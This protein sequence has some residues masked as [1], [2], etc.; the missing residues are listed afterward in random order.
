MSR[1]PKRKPIRILQINLNGSI[2]ATESALDLAVE[3]DI[4]VI[5]AQEPWVLRHVTE[6]YN[7]TRSINHSDFTQILPKP[8]D[9]DT[10]PRTATW[11][12]KD[13]PYDIRQ[14]PLE[15]EPDAQ[16][17]DLIEGEGK[18]RLV[19]LY[20][21]K[22]L[23]TGTLW[24]VERTLLRNEA[25]ATQ[26]TILL[27]D[28]NT[29]H[30]WW[31]PQGPTPNERATA[32]GEWLETHNFSL[33]N[34]IGQGTFYRPNMEQASVLDLVFTR[35]QASKRFQD[36]QLL[37]SL[38]SDHL[39][40]LFSLQ[41]KAE[42]TPLKE[43]QTRLN[44]AKADWDS[45]SRY[46][47][48]AAENRLPPNIVTQNTPI[49]RLAN[50][51]AEDTE[52]LD[53]YTKTLT[54][55]IQDAVATAIPRNK[56]TPR[57]KAWWTKELKQHRLFLQQAYRETKRQQSSESYRT[58]KAAKNR[59][60]QEIKQAKRDHWNQFLEGNSP[61][62][63]FKAMQYTKDLRRDQIPDIQSTASQIW[64]QTSVLGEAA[65][66]VSS[67]AAMQTSFSGKCTA[68]R[69]SLFPKPPWKPPPIW[70]EYT[71]DTDTWEWPPLSETELAS[72]CSNKKI[73][74]KAPGPDGI[75]QAII[76]KA[77]AAIPDTFYC[78]YSALLNIGYHPTGWKQATGVI[79]KKLGKP[80]YSVPKAYRV[81]SLLN[82]LGKV[83][84]RILAR[85]LGYLA[86]TTTLLHNS[87]IGGR[88]KKSAIDTAFILRNTV[89]RN[90]D[91]GRKTS[92][93]FLDVKGAFD[94][95]AKNQLLTIM[96]KLRLPT[97]LIAWTSSF[98][99]HRLLR[100]QFNGETEKFSAIETGIPQGSPISPILFLIYIRDLFAPLQHVTPLS[101]ID[102]IALTTS[103]TSLRKNARTL[104]EAAAT[105]Y[106]LGKDNAIEFDLAKTELIH[107]SK[108]K[109]SSTKV[110]L[111][112]DQEVIPKDIVKWLGFYFDQHL[113]FK[114]HI[115]TRT[116]QARQ[117]FERMR[118]LASTGYGLSFSALRNI[119][120]AC[121]LSI[122]D[123]G[124]PVWATTSKAKSRPLQAL[125]SKA[126][127]RILGV[128]K[129]APTL[130]S[131]VE[132]ALPPTQIRLRRI[133]QNY[134]LRSLYL[135][136]DHPLVCEINQRN[137][138][139]RKATQ[140][141]QVRRSILGVVDE[142][143]VEIQE[144][145]KK[146]W[147]QE[148]FQDQCLDTTHRGTLKRERAKERID[149]R[150]ED[151]WLKFLQAQ[152]RKEPSR[153]ATNFEWKP[154]LEIN[155]LSGTTRAKRKTA[156]AFFQLKTGHGYLKEYLYK[157]GRSSNDRCQCGKKETAKHLLLTCNKYRQERDTLRSQMHPLQL[158]I[159]TLLHTDRGIQNTL[160]FLQQTGIA[161]Q[162]WHRERHE[163]EEEQA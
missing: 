43:T 112:G 46:L 98:L 68:L 128:F 4:H 8:R 138:R 119:Y 11:I 145:R 139:R 154:R 114:T 117:A 156:S 2:A 96:K 73:K 124:A 155:K 129:T 136:R 101:Y 133:I 17:L 71:P 1:H 69:S 44:L 127:K 99:E 134:A 34:E 103:S 115:N 62:T 3:L 51:T 91:Q 120:R 107:F 5:C 141:E 149:E 47:Q 92:T 137:T 57:S 109:D 23:E 123:Y 33:G 140:L 52:L 159:T 146:P 94:H 50:P 40:I 61:K 95:V 54:E 88:Q 13:L 55:I 116:S 125:Q 53:L 152:T 31:E 83:S 142:E 111:P 143:E 37:P 41:S 113:T 80:D 30:P 16:F 42:P 151:Q 38:G 102:D 9:R 78:L 157:I 104:Q 86:E 153:Y 162:K 132:A 158:T 45:F 105:L 67:Q 160:E 29:H 18:T 89:E 48:E 82:C 6:K 144:Y 85:R 63:V 66:R 72:A 97:P 77:Y 60:F 7:N 93:L 106:A 76:A 131:E 121:V 118:R 148:P 21:E 135:Q 122:A 35:G 75:T 49:A 15:E 163:L 36:W 130:A 161:T 70:T 126:T 14:G 25:L 26:N 108:G 110:T 81:I 87:Q 24:T 147:N 56:T 79:L 65:H 28:F 32:L 150:I 27:G 22:D 74:G 20:N 39:G 10:R 100:L 84:E 19:N 59:Y 90:K 58:Y 64:T 12:R